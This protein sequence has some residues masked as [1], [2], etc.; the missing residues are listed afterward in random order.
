ML[1]D[2]AQG[3]AACGAPASSRRRILAGRAKVGRQDLANESLGAQPAVPEGE[4]FD[5]R[6]QSGHKR[7]FI[8]ARLG[9]GY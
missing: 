1:H 4:R 7:L 3:I 8:A 5:Y 6:G 2:Q 9:L